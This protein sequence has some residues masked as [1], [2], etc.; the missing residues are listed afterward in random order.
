MY[1]YCG[2]DPVDGG[3]PDGL[4]GTNSWL[5]KFGVG[6]ANVSSGFFDTITLE[7][8]ARIRSAGHHVLRIHS[9]VINTK[10]GLYRGGGYVGIGG[11][12]LVPEIGIGDE[13]IEGGALSEEVLEGTG[14]AAEEEAECGFNLSGFTKHG[15]NQIITSGTCQ[16]F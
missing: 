8:T 12:F 7:L 10:S 11:S 14:E 6:V 16:G 5:Y 15:I 9:H 4:C 3:D 1:G 13:I 2:G